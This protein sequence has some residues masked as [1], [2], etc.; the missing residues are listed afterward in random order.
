MLWC[1]M[2]IYTI[3]I[4]TVQSCKRFTDCTVPA[5]NCT[6]ILTCTVHRLYMYIKSQVDM[7]V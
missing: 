3:C 5:E 6:V 2:S 1:T 4:S 7:H